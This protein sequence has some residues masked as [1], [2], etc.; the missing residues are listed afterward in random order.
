MTET[1]LRNRY[2]FTGPIQGSQ[3]PQNTNPL[4]VLDGSQSEKRLVFPDDLPVIDHW[5][6]FR[7]HRHVFQRFDDFEKKEALMTIFLPVPSNLATQ[8][9]QNYNSEGIGPAGVGGAALGASARAAGGAGVSGIVQSVADRAKSLSG[10]EIANA[11]GYYG[12]QAAEAD[13]GPAVGAAIGGIPGA[14]GGAAVGQALKGA[15]AGAGIARNP[16][17]AVLYDGPSFRNHT[18]SY[19]FVAK[20]K[21]ES[22]ILQA[23]IT[24][25][26][27][28]MAPDIID[29][30]RGHFFDY[31]EQFDIDFHYPKYL[32]NIGPSVLKSFEV[33]YH[34]EGVPA[35]FDGELDEK[36]PV[37]V[38]LNMTFQET[39]VVTKKRIEDSNR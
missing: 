25:F 22:E 12:L 35:Y 3:E 29:G 13:L 16:H 14:I 18:F 39:F 15:I 32:F 4:A 10:D 34:G 31:P 9:D 26:K 30:E 17:L 28:H 36:A 1:T 37:T 20:N 21:A 5:V 11:I 2:A 27:Y 38:T 8:Y 6:S 19:K 33:N 7:I 23:L 24:K